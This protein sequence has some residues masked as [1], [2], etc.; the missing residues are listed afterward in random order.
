VL[1]GTFGCRVKPDKQTE[2]LASVADVMERARWLPGCLDC[3]LVANVEGGGGFSLVCEWS[4]PDGLD[5]FLRSP[6]F[7]VL[8]GM[9]I[10]MDDEPRLVVD[11]VVR[12]AGISPA[13]RRL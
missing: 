8:K 13:P 3:R 7:R 12:R 5:R 6:E 9:R 10:L 4:G 2:F 11:E 1:I